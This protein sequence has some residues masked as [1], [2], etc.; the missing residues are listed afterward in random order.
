MA[1]QVSD[2]HWKLSR[3]MEA[4]P[5][6]FRAAATF[7]GSE[8]TPYQPPVQ[9]SPPFVPIDPQDRDDEIV[10]KARSRYSQLPKTSK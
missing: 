7:K 9:T 3:S 10:T 5:Y 4:I 1:T 2:L 8:A 6:L